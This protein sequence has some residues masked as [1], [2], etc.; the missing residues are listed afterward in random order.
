MLPAIRECSD[1]SLTGVYSRD[2]TARNRAAQ[3]YGCEAFESESALLHDKRV[4]A[5][6]LSTPIGLHFEQGRHVLERGLHLLCEK[7]LTDDFATSIELIALARRAD[8]VLC[9]T[10]MYRF[11]PRLAALLQLVQS[12]DFGKIIAIS[13]L[14]YLPTLEFPGFRNS[15]SLGGGA[16][17]DVA[18]YPISL[19]RALGD[20]IA[21]KFAKLSADNHHGVDTQGAALLLLRAGGSAFLG[22]GYGAAYRNEVTVIG[23]KQSIYADYVFSKG[24]PNCCE[25]LLRNSTGGQRQE[26]SP[27]A[28]SFVEMFTYVCGAIADR[29]IRDK[30]LREASE[31]A[32][33]MKEIRAF[34]QGS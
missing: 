21:V 31:Q 5:V 32:N 2:E 22:W 33:W 30:L 7:S 6:Y 13:S 10:L 23:E 27:V 12:E 26:V 17:L 29:Q 28:D 14:F 25:L 11:H 18:C 15:A 4:N 8:V 19:A 16:F 1:T 24:G 34:S 20:P 9:E 3:E